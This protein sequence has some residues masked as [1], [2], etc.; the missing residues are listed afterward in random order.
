MLLWPCGLLSETLQKFLQLP[1][2][3]PPCAP[4]LPPSTTPWSTCCV[5]PTFVSV[6]TETHPCYD[7]GSIGEAHSP[8]RRNVSDPT[9]SATRTLA[10]PHASQMD[11]RRA[12][13]RVCTA[14]RM[15]SC[16]MWRHPKGPPASWPDPPAAR[17]QLASSQ[18][19]H[20]LISSSNV[21]SF[22][23]EENQERRQEGFWN[24][25][26][27]YCAWTINSKWPTQVIISVSPR[28]SSMTTLAR[29]FDGILPDSHS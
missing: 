19:S 16:V 26:R 10:S 18:L 8:T 24:R 6:S 29:T 17:W 15:Q 28:I 5:S 25:P 11:S 14:L 21:T 9:H 4:S 22:C 23:H 20:G 3:W 2:P 1:S 7:R 13:G 12:T 27:D